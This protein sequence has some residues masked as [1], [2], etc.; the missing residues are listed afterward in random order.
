MD[1]AEFLQQH[2]YSMTKRA[3][4]MWCCSVG[5]NQPVDGGGVRG[6][7]KTICAPTYAEAVI[8]AARYLRMRLEMRDKK[9][10]EPFDNH[11]DTR[12][13]ASED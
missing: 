1:D 9:K 10:L 4:G 3:D 8:R 11:P 5:W 12:D 2:P 6:R 13:D 7:E